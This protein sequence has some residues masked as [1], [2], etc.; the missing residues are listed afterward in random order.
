MKK[1]VWKD[2]TG[3]TDVTAEM[4]ARVSSWLRREYPANAEKLVAKR[5]GAAPVTVQKWLAGRLPDHKNLAKMA[6]EWGWRF[7]AFVNEPAVAR[8]YDDAA[9][10]RRLAAVEA[11]AA[12]LRQEVIYA[13]MVRREAD[14]VLDRSRGALHASGSGMAGTPR[15]AA[16]QTA[17][18]ATPVTAPPPAGRVGS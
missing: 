16:G 8:P 13:A 15:P 3:M 6:R 17:P 10:A 7:V 18:V 9:V 1:S 12:A 4:G 14:L 2:H 5:F 11:E